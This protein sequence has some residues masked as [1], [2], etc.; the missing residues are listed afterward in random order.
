MTEAVLNEVELLTS[1]LR[2]LEAAEAVR[3]LLARY[4]AACDRC[5]LEAVV[6]LFSEDG[7][8]EAGGRTW[9]GRECVRTFFSDAWATDRSKKTHFIVN[10]VAGELAG[11]R[12]DV[13]ST[14]L[15]TG[16]GAKL[17]VLGWGEYHDVVD[18]SQPEAAFQL[19]GVDLKWAGDVRSGWATD[20][21][22]ME[23]ACP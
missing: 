10:V 12:L 1:R 14:F 21:A 17:S 11:A 9:V 20:D 16:A 2:Q 7:C 13:R 8:V 6:A 15:Y 5:D 3:R 4:G 18:V 22:S 23:R 19:K